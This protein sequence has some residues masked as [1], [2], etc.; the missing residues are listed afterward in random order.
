MGEAAGSDVGGTRPVGAILAGGRGSRIGGAKATVA[1]GGRPLISYPLA[2]V[3]A[4][5]LEPV[6]VAKPDSTLPPLACRAIREPA[7]PRHPAHGLLAALRHA[8]GRPLI[9]VGCD[10]PFLS[11]A[12][13]SWL[14]STADPLVVPAL[15]GRPQPFPGRYGRPLLPALEAA[16]AEG[17]A[18]RATLS[19]AAPR[20]ISA[21]ELA[22]FGDP[23]RLCFNVNTP[24]DLRRAERMLETPAP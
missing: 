7:Q 4:A 22:R 10:M 16:V 8:G 20:T 3:E 11:P 19:S 21:D 15:D 9:A 24:A 13:L 2:A 12:L 17:G 6:V 5:G 1:L 18:L 23:A 14:A